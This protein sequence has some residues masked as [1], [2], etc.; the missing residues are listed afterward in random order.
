MAAVRIT[1]FFNETNKLHIQKGHCSEEA[2]I[3][4]TSLQKYFRELYQL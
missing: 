4:P 3:V 2:K 1:V